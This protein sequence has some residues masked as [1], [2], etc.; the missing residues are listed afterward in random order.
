[1]YGAIRRITLPLSLFT[2]SLFAFSCTSKTEKSV[3]DTTSALGWDSDSPAIEFPKSEISLPYDGNISAF[4]VRIDT[5]KRKDIVNA[6]SYFGAE[7]TLPYIL[8][9]AKGDVNL[10]L[11]PVRELGYVGGY[12]LLTMKGRHILSSLLI[13]GE[14][15]N[16][17]NERNTELTTCHID[18]FYNIKVQQ[19][20]ADSGLKNF[21][22]KDYKIS[23]DGFLVEEDRLHETVDISACIDAP[24]AIGS[25]LNSE[26]LRH[27]E[28]QELG[29][30]GK[31]EGLE[32][33]SCYD[34]ASYRTLRK[35]PALVYLLVYSE[36]G[37][38]AF[39]DFVI[40]KNGKVTSGLTLD[41]TSEGYPTEN[42]VYVVSFEIEKD[43]NIQ[44]TEKVYE[45]DELISTR[46][47]SYVITKE[48]DRFIKQ[49]QKI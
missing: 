38:S 23:E 25:P 12:R 3:D 18:E 41:G 29:C 13:E 4:N 5:L 6:N 24:I 15:I 2:A 30:E 21:F 45:K 44:L 28:L 47:S 16:P 8:L 33:Y 27:V 46:L 31:I 9:P 11:S 17:A 34:G 32:E 49:E 36:C 39:T 37:D 22:Y 26:T 43:Y 10:L 19:V 35:T 7:D 42:T 48:G 14:W 40:L 20:S 1:M